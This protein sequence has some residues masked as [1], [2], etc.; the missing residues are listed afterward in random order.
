[1]SSVVRQL[2]QWRAYTRRRGLELDL[3]ILDQRAGEAAERLRTEL[4][5]GVAS[6]ILGKP[7]GIFLLAADERPGR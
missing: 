7:G 3:V 2:L 5:T 1:M 4:Q 6:E